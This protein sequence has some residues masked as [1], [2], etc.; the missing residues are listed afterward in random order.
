MAKRQCHITEEKQAKGGVDMILAD[1]SMYPLGKGESVSEYVARTLKI[2]D[3]S[4]LP[5][6]LGPMGTT[7]EGEWDQVMSVIT[8]C[9]EDLHRDCPR[10][11]C[12]IRI[13]AREG[14]GRLEKKIESVQAKV[15]RKLRT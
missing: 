9:Y 12:T 5:Y 10:I 13:D 11:E 7:I 4:G 2:I 8:K 3:G 6:K 15:G 1:F 14:T